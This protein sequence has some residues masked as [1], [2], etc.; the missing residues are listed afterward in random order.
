[1]K[2]KHKTLTYAT[3]VNHVN[4]TRSRI[5]FQKYCFFLKSIFRS[6]SSNLDSWLLRPLVRRIKWSTVFF[7]TL[8][9]RSS[10]FNSISKTTITPRSLVCICFLNSEIWWLM[11]KLS[12]RWKLTKHSVKLPSSSSLVEFFYFSLVPNHHDFE[13]D[14]NKFSISFF[15]FPIMKIKEFKHEVPLVWF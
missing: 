13:L 15:S 7:S 9:R 2:I 1:M 12:Y 11:S 10:L 6:C 8:I 5:I 14:R 4:V 3:Y